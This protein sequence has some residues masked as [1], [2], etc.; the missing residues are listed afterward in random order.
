MHSLL[1]MMTYLLGYLQDIFAVMSDPVGDDQH[2]D[3]NHC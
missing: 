2:K 1:G 3:D